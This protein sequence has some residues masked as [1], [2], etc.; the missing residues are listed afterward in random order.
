MGYEHH[1]S[2]IELRLMRADVQHL[3]LQQIRNRVER[4]CCPRPKTV[5]VVE[6]IGGWPTGD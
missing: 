1:M 4:M 2:D 6:P 3:V 5:R